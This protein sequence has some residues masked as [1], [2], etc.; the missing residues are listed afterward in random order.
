MKPSPKQ[1]PYAY[2]QD[3]PFWYLLAGEALR[4]GEPELEPLFRKLS[5]RAGELGLPIRYGSRKS[6]YWAVSG[7]LYLLYEGLV[8]GL[9]RKG[10]HNM[11]RGFQYAFSPRLF[12]KAAVGRILANVATPSSPGRAVAWT[13][14]DTF[15][16]NGISVT[17][18]YGGSETDGSILSA[19]LADGPFMDLCLRA[20]SPPETLWGEVCAFYEKNRPGWYY[21]WFP[22][23]IRALPEV[24]E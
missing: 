17:E 7:R 20:V 8:P 13:V 1:P 22:G 15:M 14:A 18:D 19:C 3:A 24:V 9:G 12:P 2:V 6:L 11:I 4:R 16:A 21:R 10:F 5:E 23:K